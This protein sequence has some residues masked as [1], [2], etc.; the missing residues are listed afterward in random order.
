MIQP[1]ITNEI[2]FGTHCCIC[3]HCLSDFYWGFHIT[4]IGVSEVGG[5]AHSQ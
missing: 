3:H 5:I 2:A 1:V 4:G